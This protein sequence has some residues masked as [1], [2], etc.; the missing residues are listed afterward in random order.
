MPDIDVELL[1]RQKRTRC[2]S[3]LN[4]TPGYV[5]F[6]SGPVRVERALIFYA[7]KGD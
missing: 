3:A 2:D 6:L 4:T 5:A 1:Q 7:L